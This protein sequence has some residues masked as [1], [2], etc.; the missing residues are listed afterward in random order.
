VE[1]ADGNVLLTRQLLN[2]MDF[3]KKYT[4]RWSI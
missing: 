3:F 4:P 1:F 2:P